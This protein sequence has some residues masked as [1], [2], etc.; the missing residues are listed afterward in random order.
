[1][2]QID[3]G[4]DDFMVR[5]EHHKN[6]IGFS[7]SDHAN[8]ARQKRFAGDLNQLLGLTEPAAG[9]GSENDCRHRHGIQFRTRRKIGLDLQGV[10]AGD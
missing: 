9:S 8:G 10:K 7:F 1:M 3:V 6:R 4:S 5:A 2:A